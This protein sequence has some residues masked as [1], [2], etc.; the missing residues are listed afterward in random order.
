MVKHFYLKC[1][2]CLL[3]LG[4]LYPSYTYA[5]TPAKPGLA[6]ILFS[7]PDIYTVNALETVSIDYGY[8]SENFN[9]RIDLTV[10]EENVAGGV[11]SNT[12]SEMEY[13]FNS[14][15]GVD[16]SWTS[17]TAATTTVDF[18]DG[19]FTIWIRQINKP[20]N[21]HQLATIAAR[22]AAPNYTIDFFT[23]KTAE[24]VASTDEY[25]T[26][27]DFTTPTSG[28][29]QK[30]SLVPGSTLYLRTK[31]T[32]K[33]LASQLQTLTI[34][35][36]PAKPGI[37]I[38]FPAETTKG[39]MYS[40]HEYA[41]NPGMQDAVSGPD[42]YV[43][44]TPGKNMYI[45]LKASASNYASAVQELVVPARPT[46]PAYTIDFTNESLQQSF[47]GTDEYSL[48]I[49]MKPAYTGAGHLSI[50]P[51]LIIYFRV[52]A[53]A[54]SF[55]SDVQT[56]TAPARPEA[57]VYTIDYSAEKTNEVV[58]VSVQY[59]I[60]ANGAAATAGTGTKL[61]L[62]PGQSLYFKT[63]ATGS[64]FSSPVFALMVP[65]RPAAP[66][67]SINYSAEKTNEE[68]NSSIE[69]ATNASMN[70]AV[71]GNDSPLALAPG[72]PI[73]LR[74]KATDSS[75]GSA[76]QALNVPARPA[77]P[78]FSINYG[79]ETTAEAVAEIVLYATDDNM[80]DPKA[81]SGSIL[82]LTPGQNLYFQKQA[83]STSFK[84]V[85]THLVVPARPATPQYTIDYLQEKT[86]EGVPATDQYSASAD[87][88]QAKPGTG[89]ALSVI[90]GQ[91]LYFQTKATEFNFK[92]NVYWM[93]I[94]AR[95]ATPAFTID[96]INELSSEAVT[97]AQEYSSNSSMQ[98]AV[99][100]TGDQVA[101]VPGQNLYLRTKA[102]ANTFASEK[103]TLVV[104]ER[105][106]APTNAIVN[107]KNDTFAWTLNP[108][109]SDP[110]AYEYTTD[111][112]NSWTQSTSNQITIGHVDLA[113]DAVQVRV[114]ATANS[115]KSHALLS[116]VAFTRALG[117]KSFAAA[118]L[119]LYPNPAKDKIYLN[120]LS[121][122]ATLHIY[123]L[124]G[125]LVKTFFLNQRNN[126]LDISD[127]K[128]GAYLVK[129]QSGKHNTQIRLLKQ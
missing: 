46:A 23:E 65:A 92:S 32:A 42:D 67:F 58:P 13:S 126:E 102:S 6:K 76:I 57:P 127:L 100:G 106:D 115:F 54:T 110:S 7:S 31:A 11:L 85:V 78:V 4:M 59:S 33:T 25:A 41:Y 63:K 114:K 8:G 35:D 45:R 14:T 43:V 101:V 103:M 119:V 9:A 39:V 98:N 61:S 56:L 12:T 62:T 71:T 123:S 109:Y 105:P 37:T 97:A 44:L 38:N 125:K 107:D 5:A 113:P 122:D 73:F 29:D 79:L 99:S 91:H 80:T 18:A 120:K 1:A 22:A 68:V 118:G 48:N 93:M 75:F 89:S 111:G 94:P 87:M 20:T 116:G 90:P 36:R 17:C 53:T 64:S 81:G 55:N 117:L 28:S 34:P 104:K 124:E 96:Y 27:V 50:A 40:T 49:N 88:A 10:V 16:G 72:K 30:L 83:T 129:M 69:Y 108:D 86:T 70:G 26:A 112:G 21:R 95:P 84:S 3:L 24:E 66:A 82:S 74:V 121:D 15:N 77:A 51:S 19:G 60:T 52:K 47:A 2:V 128:A